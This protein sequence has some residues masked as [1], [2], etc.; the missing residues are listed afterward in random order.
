MRSR[1]AT[2]TPKPKT[3]DPFGQIVGPNVSKKELLKLGKCA[4]ASVP[5][6]VSRSIC[7]LVPRFTR[8]RKYIS[9]AII[10]AH[11]GYYLPCILRP[12]RWSAGCSDKYVPTN[13]YH[14][15]C[16]GRVNMNNPTFCVYNRTN[17]YFKPVSAGT[18]P[19]LLGNSLWKRDN[20]RSIDK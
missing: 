17:K 12:A 16:V 18:V 15:A 13:M 20:G 3:R 7:T 6:Y 19:E 8:E 10:S 1:D 5:D 2:I 4:W 14:H 11:A 9:L